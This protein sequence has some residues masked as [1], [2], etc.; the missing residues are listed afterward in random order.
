MARKSKRRKAGSTS[1]GLGWWISLAPD[2]RRQWVVGCMTF[3]VLVT[4]VVSGGVALG[5]LN[6]HVSRAL[7]RQA[8][9]ALS[10]VDLPARLLSLAED[11]MARSAEGLLE[12][13]WMRPELCQ[14]L[15]ERVAEVGWVSEVNFVRRSGTGRFEVSCRYRTP[16]AMVQKDDEFYLVDRHSVRLPGRYHYDPIWLLIQ[17]VGQSAPD[18]GRVWPGGDVRTGLSVI[19]AIIGSS[20]ASQITAVLVDNIAGRRDRHRS[21]IELATDRA[22]GRIRWGSAPGFEL[23]ANSVAEKLAILMENYRQT[24]RAD[25]EHPVIDISLY[26]DKF[27]IPAQ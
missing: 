15:A 17:G 24:G 23:E 18:A 5:R 21:H 11:D 22:G 7:V 25:A 3:A 6:T 19:E 26:P 13:D 20:F 10:F 27:T 8:T 16:T 1:Y 4:M 12:G 14:V 9:P 2:R